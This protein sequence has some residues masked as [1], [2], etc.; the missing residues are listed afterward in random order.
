MQ[1]RGFLSRLTLCIL[2]SGPAELRVGKRDRRGTLWFF[3]PAVGREIVQRGQ[4]GNGSAFLTAQTPTLFPLLS[5]SIPSF[6]PLSSPLFTA[7]F[8][9]FLSFFF[10]RFFPSPS[11]FSSS[12]PLLPRR[13]EEVFSHG[14][15]PNCFH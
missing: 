9:F 1:A 14:L 10:F 2:G 4:R 11:Y 7:A 5:L 12:V 8:S 13:G 6:A 15:L 3:G